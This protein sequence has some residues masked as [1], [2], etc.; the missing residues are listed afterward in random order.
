LD[1]AKSEPEVKAEATKEEKAEPVKEE[2]EI[3]YSDFTLPE[4]MEMNEEVLNNL[5]GFAKEKGLSQDDAQK[6]VDM[7]A[8]LVEQ[9]NKAIEDN[10]NEIYNTW[11]DELKA[12]KEVGG[13][14]LP[15]NVGVV[16]KALEKLDPEGEVRGLLQDS[17]L[18]D[19]PKF[20]KTILKMSKA[21]VSDSLI[22]GD[23]TNLGEG[24]TAQKIYDKS[25]HNP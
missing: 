24:M 8:G 25:T 21:F 4:N 7:G 17:R 14:K 2:K 18:I 22:K 6:I 23:A 9:T 3:V 16:L 11:Q 10:A 13:D 15:E 1:Q 20:F 5:K 12:D 19:N